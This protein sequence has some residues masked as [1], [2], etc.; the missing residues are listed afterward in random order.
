M[1]LD[2]V[3]VFQWSDALVIISKGANTCSCRKQSVL[4]VGTD[5]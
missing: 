5:G 1:V 4:E 3:F 2:V